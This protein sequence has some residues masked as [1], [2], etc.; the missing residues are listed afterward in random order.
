MLANPIGEKVVYGQADFSREDNKLIINQSSDKTIINWSDFSISTNETTKI[1]QPS[2]SSSMLNR[3]TGSDISRIYG[4]LESNGKVY[5]INQKGILIGPEGKINT[6]GFIASTLDLED[7]EFING[8]DLHFI[9]DL[10]S[11]IQN[12]G[13]IDGLDGEIILIAPHIS[14][15]GSIEA[16]RNK[17]SLLASDNVLLKEDGSNTLVKSNCSIDNKGIIESVEIE[18]RASNGNIYSLAINQEGVI[19]AQGI[20]NKNGRII[21]AAEGTI[22]TSGE[23]NA[24][25]THG[26]KI[27]ILADEIYIKNSSR[28]DASGLLAGG[29][30]L[31]GGDKK[32]INPEIK[33]SLNIRLDEDVSI[34][35]DA[36]NGDGGKIVIFAEDRTECIA[37]EISAQ[38]LG[39]YGNGGFVE[40]SGKRYLLLTSHPDLRSKNGRAGDF[41]LDP[42]DVLIRRNDTVVPPAGNIWNDAY[43]NDQLISG[44]LTID[45]SGGVGG[46]G[47]IT[48][49]NDVIINWAAEHKLT[50][51]A[52][53]NIFVNAG[54]SPSITSSA[55]NNID[56]LEMVAQ[57][58]DATQSYSGIVLNSMTITTDAGNIILNGKGGNQVSNYGLRILNSKIISSD[59]QITLTGTC[60]GSDAQEIGIYCYRSCI[61]SIGRA[62]SISGTGGAGSNNCSGVYLQECNPNFIADGGI[63]DDSGS[64]TI[65]GVGNGFLG[66]GT[67][68]HGIYCNASDIVCLH[69][70]IQ[71]D[72]SKIGSGSGKGIFIEG[73]TNISSGGN[74]IKCNGLGSGDLDISLSS[75]TVLSN[76]YSFPLGYIQMTNDNYSYAPG[77]SFNTQANGQL[78]ILP[79]GSSYAIGVGNSVNPLDVVLYIDDAVLQQ[80]SVNVG[81][82]ILGYSNGTNIAQ[83]GGISTLSKKLTVYGQQISTVGDINIGNQTLNLTLGSTAAGS[84]VINSHSYD[85]S[86]GVFNINGIISFD[87]TL[88]MF[89]GGNNIW[90]ITFTSAGHISSTSYTGNINFTWM[91]KLFG[92]SVGDTFNIV[93][94]NLNSITLGSGTNNLT[95]GSGAGILTEIIGSPHISDSYNLIGGTINS[96]SAGNGINIFSVSSTHLPPLGL[97][98]VG[99]NNTLIRPD[100]INT[101]TITLLNSGDVTTPVGA[102]NFSEMQNLTGG[103]GND[104]F[105]FAVFGSIDGN[106][107]G[108]SAGTNIIDY[109][110]DPYANNVTVNLQT[111]KATAISGTFSN[112]NEIIGDHN[113]STTNTID[114]NDS[115]GNWIIGVEDQGTAPIPG[116]SVTFLNFGTLNGGSGN[117]NFVFTG[118][119]LTGGIDGKAGNNTI[120]APDIDT[121][122]TITGF[123][124]GTIRPDSEAET[125]FSN[126]QNLIGG[127]GNDS[128]VFE[129]G[130]VI[131]GYIDGNGGSNILLGPDIN[132]IWNIT[133]L[134]KGYLD[135][136]A[137][138]ENIQ[139]LTGGILGDKFILSDLAGISG[140]LDGGVGIY[141]T[142]DYSA[143]TTFFRINYSAG[144]ATNIGFFKNIQYFI[145]SQQNFIKKYFIILDTSY[146]LNNMYIDNFDYMFNNH[147]KF[148]IRLNQVLSDQIFNDPFIE[149]ILKYHQGIEFFEKKSDKFDGVI[150]L[151]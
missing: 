12:L 25:D 115:G 146:Y 41:L 105:I 132:L 119:V 133:G 58:N 92:G 107:N 124:A 65:T 135:G 90:T 48:I 56:V 17:V 32:G 136:I 51:S 126:I 15:N 112:I 113:F 40:V 61:K 86:S 68:S 29:E 8:K 6:N 35:A 11:S 149:T 73:Q 118:S 88:K 91:S 28:I 81:E 151:Q 49:N 96:L 76:T 114:G 78:I 129:I 20:E 2:L 131:S 42:V 83:L 110:T 79:T 23:F 98:G 50:L 38:S 138:F 44:N 27:H 46:S 108:G 134:N 145:S 69:E 19:K 127:S 45:S 36:V 93:S 52:Y 34:K 1:I 101:W 63:R 7:C 87:N 147:K 122:F 100:G 95:M 59:G 39:L 43:I 31:I 75:A 37:K 70:N 10:N 33:N 9:S 139:N 4:N 137:V 102:L 24:N 14:N 109:N 121:T 80:M 60:Q 21:L 141:N 30:I 3:V 64:I 55:L 22:E 74:F 103:S 130:G 128:F 67:G 71:L 106:L 140:T 143:Y 111:Y 13:S 77:C 120:T 104:R 94:G 99:T 62:I 148:Y 84:C 85:F 144:M 72:G 150:K 5:L 26:G 18:L 116:G 57:G 117:D 16:K 82:V 53:M 97:S 66:S 123:N 47:T 125:S 89:N 54:G 142:L